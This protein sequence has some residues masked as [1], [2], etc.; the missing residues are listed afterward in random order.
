VAKS[1]AERE[2][3]TALTRA[4]SSA[5]KADANPVI[6]KEPQFLVNAEKAH[7]QSSAVKKDK[8]SNAV[9]NV[10]TSSTAQNINAKETVI[11]EPAYPARKN[12]LFNATVAKIKMSSTV[13]KILILA[14]KSV[15]KP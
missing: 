1:V 11:M 3:L 8:F 9:K 7:E 6:T 5:I 2:A 15:E 13:W 4:L 12:I 10:N 14:R